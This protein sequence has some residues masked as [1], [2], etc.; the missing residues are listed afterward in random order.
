MTNKLDAIRGY[1]P[2]ALA[3]MFAASGAVHF[4]RPKTFTG[5]VPRVLPSPKTMVYASG[6][7]ELVC[8]AGLMK[9]ERWAALASA[10]LL[11]AIF[12]AHIQMLLDYRARYGAGSWR[13][14]I[15]W[16]R[17]PLQIPLIWAALQASPRQPE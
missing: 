8:A 7:A 16:A 17:I 12:P 2:T 14:A 3:A 6:A 13:T 10:A 9:R 11:V 4:T 1:A 15:A 5:M